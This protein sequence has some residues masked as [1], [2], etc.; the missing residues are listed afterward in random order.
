MF[1]KGRPPVQAELSNSGTEKEGLGATEA[2]RPNSTGT[3]LQLLKR[4]QQDFRRAQS[5][6]VLRQQA[7]ESHY[8]IP[9]TQTSMPA[10]WGH[11]SEKASVSMPT[12]SATSDSDSASDASSISTVSTASHGGNQSQEDPGLRDSHGVPGLERL[13][14]LRQEGAPDSE[15]LLRPY[16]DPEATLASVL[17]TLAHANA[18]QRT[19]L[20]WQAQNAA[21]SD[22]RRLIRHHPEVVAERVLLLV[23]AVAPAVDA[24]RSQ[25]ALNAMV[26]LQETVQVLGHAADAGADA[27][28]AAA[29]KR[30]GDVGT[31]GRGSPLSVEANCTLAAI[32]AC[33]SEP[34][35]AAALLGS[36]AHKNPNVRAKVAAHLDACVQQDPHKIRAVPAIVSRLL[37][38]AAVYLEEGISETRAHGKGIL[39]SFARHILQEDQLPAL[40]DKCVPRASLRIK[41]EE[42]I[43]QAGLGAASLKRAEPGSG[44]STRSQGLAKGDSQPAAPGTPPT[45]D[46]WGSPFSAHRPP[47]GRM[48]ATAASLGSDSSAALLIERRRSSGASSH[49]SDSPLPTRSASGAGHTSKG[50]SAS[51]ISGR[52][53]SAGAGVSGQRAR[54]A[55]AIAREGSGDGSGR[56]MRRGV[57]SDAKASVSAGALLVRN[58]QGELV[59]A[60]SGRRRVSSANSKGGR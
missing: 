29:A 27:M 54:G 8:S 35:V 49:F 57:T 58:S 42:V 4:R 22:A 16:A 18:A 31:A 24:L 10:S 14:D 50:G 21:L 5:A 13:R 46:T 20:D 33:L 39:C 19:Q 45:R 56:Q 2:P 47:S 6:S 52:Q 53:S 17:K 26:L 28:V 55:S 37:S 36:A 3:R 12:R 9:D 1:P 34:K 23:S 30:A 51:H 44:R 15:G 11:D 59:R 43:G 41:V 38:A 32:V 40:L 7:P 48:S 25:T 60:V